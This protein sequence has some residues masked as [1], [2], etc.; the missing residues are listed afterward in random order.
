[1]QKKNSRGVAS[2]ALMLSGIGLAISVLFSF[3]LPDTVYEYM[4]TSAGIMLILNWLIILASHIKK[5]KLIGAEEEHYRSASY[6]VTSYLGIALIA[7]TI[8]GSLLHTNQRVG[9]FISLGFVAV[10]LGAYF[11]GSR[12]G[13]FKKVH[14]SEEEY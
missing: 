3:L 11:L 2:G 13:K 5:R 12:F 1:M 9:F 8:A 10:I 14:K 7:F 4:T 6:P